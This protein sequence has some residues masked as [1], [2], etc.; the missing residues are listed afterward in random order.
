MGK[1]GSFVRG[2]GKGQSTCKNGWITSYLVFSDFGSQFGGGGLVPGKLTTL[3]L[4]MSSW[5]ACVAE[6]KESQGKAIKIV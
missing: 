3:L 5:W 2:F 1:N 4:E 6:D